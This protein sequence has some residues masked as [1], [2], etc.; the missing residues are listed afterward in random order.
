MFLLGKHCQVKIDC[1]LRRLIA[2]VGLSVFTREIRLLYVFV[3]LIFFSLNK[4]L[5]FSDKL[6]RINGTLY[7]EKKKV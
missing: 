7:E 1:S 2:A 4:C 6:N 3:S 5:C